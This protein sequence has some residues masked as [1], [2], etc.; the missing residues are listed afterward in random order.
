MSNNVQILKVFLMLSFL[1]MFG[2]VYGQHAIGL[3]VPQ[4]NCLFGYISDNP[5]EFEDVVDYLA[6]LNLKV[7]SICEEEFLIYVELNERYKD[8][9]VLFAKIERRFTGNCYFKSKENKIPRYQKCHDQY[10]KETAKN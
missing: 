2:K 5:K 8:Y 6:A 10:I 4:N 7:I 9:T 3:P 1:V